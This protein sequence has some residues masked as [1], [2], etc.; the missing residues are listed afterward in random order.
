MRLSGEAEVDTRQLEEDG[1]LRRCNEA[2]A[3]QNGTS[4]VHHVIVGRVGNSDHRESAN[5]ADRHRATLMGERGREQLR[6]RVVDR[7][8]SHVHEREPTLGCYQANDF[9]GLDEPELDE[10]LTEPLPV[11]AR[12]GECEVELA[13]LEQACLGEQRAERSI[14]CNLGLDHQLA[15]GEI[16]GDERKLRREVPPRSVPDLEHRSEI[17]GLLFLRSHKSEPVSK[18]R[19]ELPCGPIEIRES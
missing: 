5:E 11:P 6:S 17:L 14:P 19:A 16:G 15:E 10:H 3:V 8:P 1:F 2:N 4:S 12:R 7:N 13:C 9:S 18:T